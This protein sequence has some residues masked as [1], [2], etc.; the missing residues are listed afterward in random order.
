MSGAVAQV[1]NQ[2][3]NLQ[4]EYYDLAHKTGKPFEAYSTRCVVLIGQVKDL[5]EE[6]IGSFE[7]SRANSKDVLILTFDE[8]YERLV[9]LQKIIRGEKLTT[10]N[11]NSK[12]K[13]ASKKSTKV[14]PKASAQKRMGQL[15]LKGI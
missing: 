5:S 6:Q 10:G 8:V 3:D 11:K 2:R 9:A 4:K 14:V 1:L 15:P 12:T 7:L 13:S